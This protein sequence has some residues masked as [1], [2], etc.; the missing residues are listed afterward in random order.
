VSPATLILLDTHVLVWA[1]VSPERLSRR[2][3]SAIRRAEGKGRVGIASISLWELAFLFARGR[4]QGRGTLADAVDRV[5]DQTRVAIHEITPAIAVLA[6]QFPAEFP[7]DPQDRLIAATAVARGM[8][9][10]TADQAILASTL[11]DTVW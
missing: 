9:L 3:A 4:L 8:P 7:R 10:V 11:V 5:L 1:A 6:Q 2:A